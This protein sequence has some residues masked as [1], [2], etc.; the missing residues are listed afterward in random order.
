M[1]AAASLLPLQ[2]CGKSQD[3]HANNHKPAVVEKLPVE[4][5][6]ATV[7][8]TEEA[9]LRLGIET[10]PI[11]MRAV[12]Q[13]RTFGGEVMA[14]LG[15][16]LV[17]SAP[18][19]GV[20]TQHTSSSIPLPGDRVALNQVVVDLVPLLSPSR[21]V[22]TPAERVQLISARA[23]VIAAQQTALGDLQRS[24]AEVEAAQIALARADKLF[25]DGAGARRAVDD[26]TANLNIA[27]SNLQAAQER[28]QQL[29]R[30][31]EQL[32]S[33]SDSST[34]SPLELVA[35]I[36]GVLRTVNVRV[37]QTVAV[38][39][40]LF[41]VMNLD[42]IWVRVPVFVDLLTTID[43][44]KPAF[45]A[46]LSGQSL[47]VAMSSSRIVAQPISAP[48]SADPLSSSA[49]L[50]YEVHNQSLGLR[51]GQRIGVDLPL[52]GQA[53]S[54]TTLDSAIIYDIFG[55]TWVYAVTGQREY[56][57]QRVLL[58]WVDGDKAILESGPKIGTQVVTTGAAEL[59]GTE[60]GVG[61]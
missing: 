21:D 40:P 26:A 4:T 28:E 25:R 49:D 3:K 30:M 11:Q 2:G 8:L 56:T 33:S 17:V 12:S 27:Q 7:R 34:A 14:P 18:V 9:A 35:P 59:F 42:T 22:M 24:E 20:I 13:R 54:L 60:F 1:F 41:E 39:A 29:A 19:P 44:E 10:T 53:E 38:G 61:K 47:P 45:L 16:V 46:T 58:G 23:N 43:K 5:E 15:N 52:I 32:K 57:R 51:P 50:Y 36:E 6:L 31:L 37:G 48:P 55:G